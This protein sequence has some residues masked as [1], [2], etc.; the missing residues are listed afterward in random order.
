MGSYYLLLIVISGASMWVSSTLKRKFK[1]YSKIQLHSNMSGKEIAEKMLSDHGIK[2]VK[3]ISVRGSLTDHYNPQKKTINLSESVFNE[4]N[5]ASAAV[6]AHECGHAVQHANG[7]EWLQLRSSLVPLVGIASNM[8]MIII[9]GG[10]LLI[11]V[12][13]IGF[14]IA[15]IGLG[16]FSMG[17]LFSFIT[18]PVE[19]DA[20][21][22]ALAWLQRKSI[23]TRSE[24]EGAQDALKW[25]ART[26]VVAALS[27]LATLAY[28]A[29][30]I[31]G[32]RRN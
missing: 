14:E 13:P 31:F 10:L 18:L 15:V 6:A 7:Y 8:S 27:S 26:Y 22:R 29:F 11:N 5:A 19:Y 16:L 23:V 25:A 4:R 1:K 30:Q 17:T 2:D 21:N 32:G 24:F 12:I 20:S 9:I 3:I 28:F